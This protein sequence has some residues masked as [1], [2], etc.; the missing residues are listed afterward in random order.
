MSAPAAW[1]AIVALLVAG[2]CTVTTGAAVPPASD[3]GSV[4]L[5]V[6]AAASL[7]DALERARV[8]WEA[9][10]PTTTL[11]LATDSSA[12]LRTQIEQG[13]PADLFL[14]ADTGNPQALADAGLTDGDPVAFAG[15]ALAVIV[16]A[17][18]PAGIAAATDIAG[19]GVAVIAAGEEVPITRYAAEVVERLGIADGYEVNVVSREDNVKAVATKIALGEG[20]A[21]LVYATDAAAADG[22]EMIAIPAGSNVVA[23]YAGVVSKGSSQPAAARAFLDWLARGDGQAI[24]RELGFLPPP[25]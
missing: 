15:N 5:T 7:G 20:D 1:V 8:A 16:P 23:T 21:A 19:D 24:L 13:A 2:G 14:S 9:D 10:H 11:T 12:A 17:G 4:R 3:A 18:N 6:F 25:P 22:V